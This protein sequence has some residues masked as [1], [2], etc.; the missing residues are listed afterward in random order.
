[1]QILWQKRAKFIMLKKEMAL[2][3]LQ[4]CR[5]NSQART[6][7]WLARFRNSSTWPL[8]D[9]REMCWKERMRIQ[10]KM[11]L[12]TQLKHKSWWK[13]RNWNRDMWRLGLSF[14]KEELKPTTSSQLKCSTPRFITY[15][16][17]WIPNRIGPLVLE[18][19]RPMATGATQLGTTRFGRCQPSQ[20]CGLTSH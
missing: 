8:L 9:P 16:A 6:W 5:I 17:R 14:G 2:L 18:E 20:Q 4:W 13:K 10:H 19:S 1:M 3:L 7:S 11:L 15:S 12:T